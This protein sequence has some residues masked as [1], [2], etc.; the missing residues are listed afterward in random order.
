MGLQDMIDD[1]IE[2]P[3]LDD[4]ESDSGDDEKTLADIAARPRLGIAQPMIKI[5]S[6]H[7][8]ICSPSQWRKDFRSHLIDAQTLSRI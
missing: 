8:C 5:G 1:E 4:A 6:D 2:R 7:K 3:K